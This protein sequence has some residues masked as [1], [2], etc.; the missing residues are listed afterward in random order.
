MGDRKKEV[1]FTQWAVAEG[2]ELVGKG[3][4]GGVKGA[5]KRMGWG[6]GGARALVRTPE[7]AFQSRLA[8]LDII[9]K[10]LTTGVEW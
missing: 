10:E 7:T 4:A 9:E 8:A 5:L 1:L 3:G 6:E 2:E